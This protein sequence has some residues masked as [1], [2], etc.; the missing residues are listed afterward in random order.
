M[1]GRSESCWKTARTGS[2][3]RPLLGRLAGDP[4]AVRRGD[5]PAAAPSGGLSIIESI[6]VLNPQP[7]ELGH[8]RT[9]VFYNDSERFHYERPDEPADLRSGIVCSPNNFVYTEPLDD[10]MMRIS[11]LAN[12]D[13]WTGMDE[14]A[15]RGRSAGGTTAWRPRPCGLCPTSATP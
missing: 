9:I 12:Y 13:R 6:S 14:A 3:K 2:P 8:D 4:A 7:R 15:Y 5:L 1:A 11:A 10:G